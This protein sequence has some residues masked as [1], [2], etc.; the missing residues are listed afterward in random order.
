L[1]L[2]RE[3]AAFVLGARSVAIES[4]QQLVQPNEISELVA[5]L[6]REKAAAITMEDIQV[7]AARYLAGFRQTKAN[8]RSN[9]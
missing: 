9:I 5:H 7:N 1:S 3:G 6:C 2:A 4:Q 8:R